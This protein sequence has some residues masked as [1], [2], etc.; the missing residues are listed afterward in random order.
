[1]VLDW[2]AGQLLVDA[3]CHG[4]FNVREPLDSSL[5]LAGEAVPTPLSLR[6]LLNQGIEGHGILLGLRLLILSGC[7]TGILDLRGAT[8]RMRSLTAAVLEAGADASM[9]ALWSIDDKATYLLVVRFAQLWLPHIGTMPPAATLALAQHWLRTVTNK[10]LRT[11]RA[12]DIPETTE[13]EKCEVGCFDPRHDP[14][15][16][17]EVPAPDA[18]L[19]GQ[20]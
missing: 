20:A 14:W 7:Q 4:S 6:E 5:A 9:G 1:M 13:E 19:L 2:L 12:E 3:C 16:E 15:R 18:S 8:D 10:A 11:W 17:Q